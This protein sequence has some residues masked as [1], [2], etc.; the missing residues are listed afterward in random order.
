MLHNLNLMNSSDHR[1]FKSIGFVPSHCVSVIN[2]DIASSF[3]I[4]SKFDYMFKS[5]V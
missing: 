1:I 2:L 5:V 3:S 4:F